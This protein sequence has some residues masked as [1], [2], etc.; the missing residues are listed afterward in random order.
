MLKI[1]VM[2]TKKNMIPQRPLMTQ[3]I[4]PRH[5][6]SWIFNGKTNSG[7]TNALM[8]ILT[9]KH[10]YGKQD[11]KGYFDE[12]FLFAPTSKADDIFKSLKLPKENIFTDFDE[13]E[14]KDIIEV[15]KE[16]VE[17]MG[18]VKAPR[19]CV[20]FEDIQSRPRFLKSK[21]VKQAF[22]MN[23]HFSMTTILCSQAW[24][25][26]PK[27]LRLQATH[28]FFFKAPHSETE[29]LVD[30]FTPPGRTKKEFYKLV[31]IATREKYNFL[32]INTSVDFETS[33]RSNLDTILR[34]STDFQQ[35]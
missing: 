20:I 33:Y 14:L 15:Q 24:H 12:I 25:E 35:I 6:T 18:V 26:T 32:Y 23:R 1:D 3:N 16:L 5:P 17:K 29:T 30:E 19:I 27:T 8:S 2:P 10:F 28:I 22:I 11:G 9:K 34:F 4:I 13:T 7:K 21:S 31:S